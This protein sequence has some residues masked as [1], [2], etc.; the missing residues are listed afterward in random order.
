MAI[1]LIK[2]VGEYLVAPICIGIVIIA[3]VRGRLYE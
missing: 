2:A 1:E 3:I